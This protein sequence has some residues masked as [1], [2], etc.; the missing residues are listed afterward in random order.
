MSGHSGVG[1]LVYLAS[2]CDNVLQMEVLSI[3]RSVEQNNNAEDCVLTVVGKWL[4][5]RISLRGGWIWFAVSLSDKGDAP[6]ELLHVADGDEGF[7]ILRH[8]LLAFERSGCRSLERPI[9]LGDEDGGPHSWL[10]A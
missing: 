4:A 9:Q 8:L 2:W 1:G 7:T 5:Y 6:D 10:I 3:G